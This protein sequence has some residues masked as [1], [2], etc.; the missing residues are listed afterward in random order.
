MFFP[1]GRQRWEKSGKILK[2]SKGNLKVVCVI[3]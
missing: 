2:G 3:L 1:C